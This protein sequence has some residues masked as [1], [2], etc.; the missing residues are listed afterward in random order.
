MTPTR[1]QMAGFAA[2]L[3]F[4]GNRPAGASAAAA[5][6]EEFK[7]GVCTYSFHEFARKLTLTL[8]GQLGVKY[9]SVKDFHL[10]Y[11]AAPE[12]IDRAKAAFRKA[13]LTIVSGGT[14]PLQ[15]DNPADL[16]KHFAYA[17]A[18]GMPMMV[19]APTHNTLD[20]V[21]KLAREFD[22]KVAIHNHGPED[23]HFPTPKSV[24]DAVKGRDPRM[25]LCMDLGHSLRTGANVVE[26]IAAA[27]SRLLDVHIKDLEDPSDKKSQCDVGR[28]V[29]PVPAIFKQ[30]KKMN[31][32]GCVNLEYEINSDNPVP[33]MLHSFGYM[34]GVLA[35]L[36]A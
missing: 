25:G 30:L 33:G 16:K 29:M 9:V 21:E 18:C 4:A 23:K 35:G 26:E 7:L 31:Y 15:D 5:A 10:P 22:I 3:F 27:G 28:G 12:E 32:Q 19:A 2:G 11:T 36:A 1:R 6:R 34:R 17:K 24:L 20:E 14:I 13:G 8:I